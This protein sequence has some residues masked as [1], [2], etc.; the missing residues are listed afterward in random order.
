MSDIAID[1]KNE[2]NAPAPGGL[3]NKLANIVCICTLLVMSAWLF[4]ELG[5]TTWLIMTAGF[6]FVGIIVAWNNY[7]Q[8]KLMND[9]IRNVA[10]ELAPLLPNEMSV[11]DLQ[12]G[13]ELYDVKKHI[14][15]ALVKFSQTNQFIEGVSSSLASHASSMQE[16]SDTVKT[17][18]EHQKIEA[19]GARNDLE[20]L[21]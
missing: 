9:F 7:R 5:L 15:S 18:L 1:E 20:R 16:I 19:E 12:N 17:D 6:L 2:M 10:L 8:C 11:A 3:N 13:M 4:T 14:H 21:T